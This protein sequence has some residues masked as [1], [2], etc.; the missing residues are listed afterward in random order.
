V[1]ANKRALSTTTKHKN[2]KQQGYLRARPFAPVPPTG[3][4][5]ELPPQTASL[6]FNEQAGDFF[7]FPF[8]LL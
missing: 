8:F 4:L 5:V 6:T 1:R 3:K 2:I 7:G